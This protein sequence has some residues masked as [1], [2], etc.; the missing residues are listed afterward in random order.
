MKTLEV[1]SHAECI[2]KNPNILRTSQMAQVKFAA[3]SAISFVLPVALKNRIMTFSP[4][5]IHPDQRSSY[6][7]SAGTDYNKNR[8]LWKYEFNKELSYIPSRHLTNKFSWFAVQRACDDMGNDANAVKC[9]KLAIVLSEELAK[10]ESC[11]CGCVYFW[12]NM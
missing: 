8:L 11:Y 7:F 9:K 3:P 4:S 5:S 6:F 2:L 10:D 12:K 1:N